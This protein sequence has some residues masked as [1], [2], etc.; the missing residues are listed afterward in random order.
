MNETRDKKFEVD[1]GLFED[2]LELAL[3]L[4][5]PNATSATAKDENMRKNNPYGVDVHYVLGEERLDFTSS[6]AI[7]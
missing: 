4:V 1:L 7:E 3:E 5:T 6:V 2:G